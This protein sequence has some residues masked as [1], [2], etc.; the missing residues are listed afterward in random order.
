MKRAMCPPPSLPSRPCAA[1]QTMML[2]T[3][4]SRSIRR[5]PGTATAAYVRSACSAPALA[6]APRAG[7]LP[8]RSTHLEELRALS[9]FDVWGGRGRREAAAAGVVALRRS[10]ALAWRTQTRSPALTALG[11]NFGPC[12]ARACLVCASRR[13]RA[14][15]RA[16]A[17]GAQTPNTSRT[18]ANGH[19][20]P[21]AAANLSVALRTP[22]PQRLTN[23]RA[24]VLERR[25]PLKRPARLERQRAAFRLRTAPDRPAGVR[26]DNRNMFLVNWCGSL[27]LARSAASTRGLLASS[28]F[29]SPLRSSRTCQMRIAGG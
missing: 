14:Q 25:R 17:A 22:R 24:P 12:L 13:R 3:G 8:C 20:A 28:A 16:V 18:V 15:C 21:S 29:C 19:A 1:S 23:A 5:P 2:L 11:Q 9:L 26:G 7:A 10:S 6:G 4:C 27:T